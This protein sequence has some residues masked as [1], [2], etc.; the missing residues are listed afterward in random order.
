MKTVFDV[1]GMTCASCTAHVEKAARG[2]NGV[3]GAQASLLTDTL[4]VEGDFDAAA[5]AAAVHK[6]GYA[7]SPQGEKSEKRVAVADES[8]ALRK[9]LIASFGFLIPLMYVA[10]GG[11][12][13]LPVPAFLTGHENAAVFILTQFLL[14]LPIL[15]LNRGYFTRGF[16]SLTRR[17]PNMDSLIAVG[18]SA[19]VLYGLYALYAVCYGLGHGDHA[20][21][22]Q[23]HMD[24]YFESGGMIVTLISLGKYLE[25]RA[26]GRTGEAIEKLMKLAPDTATRL[27]NG[28]ET[29]IPLADARAGDT[30]VVRPGQRV[31]ADGVIIEGASAFD[32]SA[33]TG[34]SM[35]VDKK[36]GDRVSTATVALSGRVVFTAEK[37]GGDTSLS[38]IIRLVEEASASKAPIARLA[39]RISGVF[40][41]CVM[42]IALITCAVW[43]LLGE[44]FSFALTS[45]VAVLVISCPCALGLAT[46]VAVMVGTGKGAECG[47]LIK[48][49]AAIEA[50]RKVTCVVLDKTGTLTRGKPVVTDVMPLSGD[51]EGLL[52]AARALENGSEH[53]LAK[54]I[55]EYTDGEET[56]AVENFKALPG[57][58]VTAVIAGEQY[59]AGNAA[60]MR[61]QGVS[62]SESGEAWANEGKTPVFFARGNELLGMIAI[63]DTLKESSRGAVKA[64]RATGRRVV[65]L[66]GD[67]ER[68]ARAVAGE[69]GIDDVIADVLPGD[70]ERVVRE[71]Q[72]KGDTVAMIGD[73]VNDA[74]A[75]TRADVGVA[76]GAGSDI[77]VDSADIVLVRSDLN[78]AVT[79]FSLSGAMMRVIK[80]NLFWAFI[81]NVVGIPVA[82]GVFYRA[83]GLR[84]DPMFAAAA[85]SVSSVT[86]VMNALRLRRFRPARTDAPGDAQP[87][88]R[89]IAVEG[90]MCAHCVATV[91]DA[92]TSLGLRDVSVDLQSGRVTYAPNA[93]VPDASVVKA[94]ED[95]DYRAKMIG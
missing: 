24:L 75:L 50:A 67:N 20:L 95:A 8:G 22:N 56:R 51:R 52:S 47:V 18:A 17:A 25:A 90:M 35:P 34:E 23:F 29:E 63:A 69:A 21:V 7:A 94:I 41:P 55:L 74:P 68:T 27:E 80:Q 87:N 42:A 72:D 11:M 83:F 84:L 5:V 92:L 81:Y 57:H 43:L 53:P 38:Q 91:T 40:V 28:V 36:A 4:S 31:P 13:G 93:G 58:G 39:D 46:P 32:E 30:L 60:L 78:D 3:T 10:M 85:M 48:S 37:V 26:R 49:A 71:L 65:M 88:R 19:A 45:A 33:L 44:R 54:A 89:V 59:F 77:A 66:T 61:E 1:R 70:K 16:A 12:I 62:L 73:G 76:I 64:L 2:V 82:A 15:I 6:A 14:V 9:R 86:V 79:A